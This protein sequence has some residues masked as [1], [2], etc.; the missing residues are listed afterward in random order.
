MGTIPC[1]LFNTWAFIW[2]KGVIDGQ[3]ADSEHISWYVTKWHERSSIWYSSLQSCI[4]QWIGCLGHS[5]SHWVQACFGNKS[6]TLELPSIITWLCQK[7]TCSEIVVK[8]QEIGLSI[9]LCLSISLF[10][11]QGKGSTRRRISRAV[12]PFKPALIKKY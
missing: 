10:W 3:A 6:V 1:I 11:V 2:I 12:G 7:G 9:Q 8:E 4:G 5:T